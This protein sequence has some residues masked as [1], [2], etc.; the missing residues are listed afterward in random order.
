[1]LF[2]L[3]IFLLAGANFFFFFSL[4]IIMRVLVCGGAGYI[5][6]HLVRELLRHSN[7]EV[8]IADSL[9]A[10]HGSATHVDTEKNFLLKNS[11]ASLEKA[12]KNGRRF[13]KL[14]VG[15][16]RD[17][18]FLERVFTTHGPIDAVVH[19]CAY[20]MVGESVFDP[21]RYYD[22]NVIGMLRILQTMHKFKCDKL[23]LSSTA[24]LFGNPYAR[25]KAGASDE[26]NPMLPIHPNAKRL[27]ES[28]Y[29]TTKLVDEYMLKDCAV[30][31][32]IKSVCLRYFNACG[33]DADGDIGET[34]EPESHLIPLIL[35]VPLADKINEYNAIHHPERKKVNPFISIFGT[36]YPTPDGTCIRDY[37]HVK[38][39]SSAH[40]KALDYMEKLTPADKDKYFST[41]NL[42]TSKGYSVR[43]VIEAARR[44]TGH[45]IPAKEE[46][47][48]EGDPPVL[49]ASGEEAA[50]ALG[51]KLE[52]DS[53]DKI[54]ESAWRFHCNHP[55]GYEGIG[56]GK[57]NH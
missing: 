36:D 7:H 43:E 3:F 38:D 55:F 12:K 41:F 42:G 57:C 5:G 49:V 13:A 44:V 1:M 32:G 23:V 51:W 9:E 24:A 25:I 45:A 34:H 30:A 8:V 15:D 17:V 6:T 48:R 18:S 16:V 21:L 28:P 10:A 46:Q 33:A 26:P 31:Y 53:I 20:I 4:S 29:G 37:V 11:S 27:P 40:I 47:R 2:L 14:E 50:T 22:N 56:S 35:R 52:Y 19:M 39:L 54:I